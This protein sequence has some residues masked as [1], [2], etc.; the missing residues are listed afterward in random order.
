MEIAQEYLK[1]L[2]D[3]EDARN[4]EEGLRLKR[5]KMEKANGWLGNLKGLVYKRDEEG[6]METEEGDEPARKRKKKDAEEGGEDV[7]LKIRKAQYKNHLNQIKMKV[8]AGKMVPESLVKTCVEEGKDV[9]ERI[10]EE[11]MQKVRELVEQDIAGK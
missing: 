8:S 7:A 9:G 10:P 11:L 5:K 4:V 6:R 1:V 2:R 3:L